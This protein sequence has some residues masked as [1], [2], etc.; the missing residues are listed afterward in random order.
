VIACPNCHTL[1]PAANINT[2]RLHPCPG[3]GDPIRAD[4]FN[5]FVRPADVGLAAED[6][7]VDTGAECFNHP[8][9]PA[10]STCDV[11]G[12]M[13]CGLCRID[14]DDRYLC[15]QCLKVGRDKHKLASMQHQRILNDSIALHLAFWP[16]PTVF[17]TWLTAPAAL[18]FAVRHWRTPAGVLPRR[19][20]KSILAILLAV[21]QL[22]GWIAF[23]AT[24]L[25]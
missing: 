11:C 16:M 8:G 14:W 9:K 1:Q 5:A 17:L 21:G 19:Y 20:A 12:R 24:R 15:L 25:W 10:L 22:F 13:L 3:C 2:G 18:F 7:L 4:A 23:L 6:T